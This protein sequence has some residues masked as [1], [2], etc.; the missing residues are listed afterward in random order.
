MCASLIVPILLATRSHGPPSRG[1]LDALCRLERK[2]HPHMQCWYKTTRGASGVTA[3]HPLPCSSSMLP[4][5]AACLALVAATVVHSN[6]L[7]AAIP[8]PT[9]S[10][11]WTSRSLTLD[12]AATLDAVFSHNSSDHNKRQSWTL[13]QPGST[14]VVAMQLAVV[15]PTQLLIVDRVQTNP[16]K[17]DGHS[18]WASIYSLKSN[19]ARP[20][21]LKTNR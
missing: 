3:F 16:L 19:T 11:S 2:I 13:T 10:S 4:V 21:R 6:P 1:S 8:E 20:V 15:S 5:A 17:V 9:D 7:P 12:T 14:G 18:A